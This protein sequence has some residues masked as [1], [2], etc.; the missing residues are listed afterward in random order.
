MIINRKSFLLLF[1]IWLIGG[2]SGGNRICIPGTTQPCWCLGGGYQGVQVCNPDGRAWGVCNCGD[3]LDGGLMTDG[4]IGIDGGL[5]ENGVECIEA[6]QCQSGFCT[7][8]VCCNEQCSAV[9]KSC[10]TDGGKNH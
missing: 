4:G 2:C 8:G 9:C 5:K 1:S 3:Q 7:D 10:N 6:N